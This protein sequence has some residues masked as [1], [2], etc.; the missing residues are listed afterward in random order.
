MKKTLFNTRS[1]L[2]ILSILILSTYNS[3]IFSQNLIYPA[4]TT[5]S[6][7]LPMRFTNSGARGFIHHHRVGN[8]F[9]SQKPSTHIYGVGLIQPQALPADNEAYIWL[10]KWVN[11]AVVPVDSVN[12]CNATSNKSVVVP[13]FLPSPPFPDLGNDFDTLPVLEFY[14]DVSH[15]IDDTTFYLCMGTSRFENDGNYQYVEGENIISIQYAIDYYY[16]SSITPAQFF[17]NHY[18]LPNPNCHSIY[19]IGIFPIIDTTGRL[20]NEQLFACGSIGKTSV[21]YTDSRIHTLHW[22]D[23]IGHCLYQVAVGL[24]NRPFSE[25]DVFETTDTILTYIWHEYGEKKAFRVRAM[26][27][28]DTHTVWRPWSDTI[29]FV[30]PYY[31]LALFSN[32]LSMGYVNGYGRFDPGATVLFS[33]TPKTGFFFNCWNDGDTTNPREITIVCDTS[34][35]AF[36]APLPDTGD[37]SGNDRIISVDEIELSISPNPAEDLVTINSSVSISNIELYDMQGHLRYSHHAKSNSIS[38]SVSKIPSG[39]YIL[40]VQT[41][42]GRAYTKLVRR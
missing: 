15:A 33:A 24:A 40:C 29:Q 35:T 26:C 6:Y 12:I 34:F 23:T 22:S 11:G 4:D 5:D 2:L 16:D 18:D 28:V 30:C 41:E 21:E 31:K 36:F 32:D 13:V 39:I 17:R 37:T 38:L 19:F 1:I 25:Y 20:L 3:K 10:Y 7:I 8:G 27:C 14:F 9:P 42:R